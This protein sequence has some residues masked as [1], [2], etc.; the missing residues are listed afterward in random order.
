MQ[1]HSSGEDYLETILVIQKR[2]GS[3]RS[4]EVA[5]ALNVS[6]PS[7]S[8]A[9]RLLQNGG[10]LVMN[11][12]KTLTLTDAGREVAERVYDRHCV[13]KDG[14]VSLGVDPAVAEQDACRI[15]HII[16]RESFDKIKRLWSAFAADGS[17]DKKGSEA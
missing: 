13:L 8:K 16:S 3:V 14:L 9:I 4:V 5:E 10:F 6:K 15:E 17:A 12:N 11:E 1:L 7:V 2:K